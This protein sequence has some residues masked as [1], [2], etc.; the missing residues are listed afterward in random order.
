VRTAR[1]AG[2]S[3]AEDLADRAPARTFGTTRSLVGVRCAQSGKTATKE[4][5]GRISWSNLLVESPGM[6][7][8]SQPVSLKWYA[9]GVALRSRGQAVDVFPSD[10][11]APVVPRKS[12]HEG[13]WPNTRDNGANEL[14]SGYR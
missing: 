9:L 11:Y 4:S 3:M 10:I 14:I 7:S 5:P 8:I 2:P 1:I 13:P 12:E 6:L